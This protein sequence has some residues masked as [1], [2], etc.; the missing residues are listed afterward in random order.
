VFGGIAYWLY[1]RSRFVRIRT[2]PRQNS[3]ARRTVTVP[4]SRDSIPDTRDDSDYR[5]IHGYS[6]E[7]TCPYCDTGR[8]PGGAR[9]RVS[10]D[11]QSRYEESY[12]S[13]ARWSPRSTKSHERLE[14][15]WITVKYSNYCLKCS[16]R[17]TEGERALWKE[18]VGIWHGNCQKH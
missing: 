15:S 10:Q 13:N 2:S 9:V 4:P 17:I 14:G 16:K 6:L 7:R 12:R 3:K 18:G 1:K 5:C 8:V 11:A